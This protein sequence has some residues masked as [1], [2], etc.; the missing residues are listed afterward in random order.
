ML[1]AYVHKNFSAFRDGYLS[2]YLWNI[3]SDP[4]SLFERRN[5][6]ACKRCFS[7]TLKETA[8]ADLKWPNK[9]PIFLDRI[10]NIPLYPNTAKLVKKVVRREKI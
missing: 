1:A 10:A 6:L 3:G 2:L 5:V 9:E 4:E 7:Q 8:W